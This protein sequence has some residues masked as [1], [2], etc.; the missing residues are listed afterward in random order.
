MTTPQTLSQRQL[1]CQGDRILLRAVNIETQEACGS[2]SEFCILSYINEGGSAVCYEA[3]NTTDGTHGRLK[4]FY[5]LD[6]SNSTPYAILRDADNQLYIPEGFTSSYN[7]FKCEKE[8]FKE[9]YCTLSLQKNKKSGEILN[10]Y[11]PTFEIYEG[12]SKKTGKS[13]GLYIWTRHDKKIITFSD[14]C[15][16]VKCDIQQ[17][18]NP[19]LHLFNILTSLITL[20]RCISALHICDLLHLDIK[21]QNF[22]LAVDENSIIDASNISLFDINTLSLSY[23]ENLRAAYSEGFSA[24]E[25]R[26]SKPSFRSDIYSLG[27]VLFNS[28]VFFDGFDGKYRDEMYNDL[29]R[30]VNSSLLLKCSDCN[31]NAALHDLLVSILQKCLARKQDARY[32]ACS[33]LIPDLISARAFLLPEKASTE[34]DR[35]GLK[36]SYTDLE[37]YFDKNTR[38]GAAGALQ[39]LMFE[40][41][42]YNYTNQNGEVEI[43]VL[44]AGTYAQK[45]LDIA[46]EVSQINGCFAKISAFS[47]N[48]EADKKRYLSCR[49]EFTKF[50]DVDTCTCTYGKSLGS[51]CFLNT[52][53]KGFSRTNK[54][55][56][57][58][59]I[60]E[61]LQSK[62]YTYVFIALGS[63]ELNY[64]LFKE[65]CEL[66]K[67]LG[68]SFVHSQSSLEPKNQNAVY[69]NEVIS[70]SPYYSQLSRMALNCHLSWYDS[71]YVDLSKIK[72]EFNIPYNFN[73]SLSNVLSIKYKLHSIGI[74]DLSDSGK[75]A[76]LFTK[77]CQNNSEI[78]KSLLIS[79]HNRW[80]VNNI[81]QGYR[82]STDFSTL[83]NDIKDKKNKL[84]PC[85]VPAN[86]ACVL[87]EDFWTHNSCE[88]W[89]TA[90]Q[91]ELLCLDELDRASVLLHRHFKETAAQVRQNYSLHA[92]TEKISSL[93]QSFP[94][95]QKA[96]FSFVDCLKEIL[97]G[98]TKQT[99][100]Y[101]HRLKSVQ[102]AFCELPESLLSQSNQT[103]QSIQ[104]SF[105]PILQSC[106]YIDFK[107][108]DRDLIRA[109]PFILTYSCEISLCVPLDLTGTRQSCFSNIH[110]SLLVNP[111]RIFFV[112][113]TSEIHTNPQKLTDALSYAASTADSR[114]MQSQIEVILLHNQGFPYDLSAVK[115]TV[116]SLSQRIVSCRI[117]EYTSHEDLSESL[118]ELLTKSAKL[119]AAEKNQSKTS[120]LL[121]NTDFYSKLSSYFSDSKTSLITPDDSCL[122][123]KYVPHSGSLR[124]RDILNGAES[125][126]AETFS[127]YSE[128]YSIC[129]QSGVRK[130]L[131]DILSQHC[132][133]SSVAAHFT[134]SNKKRESQIF[135]LP[136]F[137]R[138]TLTKL[139]SALKEP[140]L[141]IISK[142]SRIEY[143]SEQTLSV[144]IVASSD[145]L[146]SLQKLFSKPYTLYDSS[147]ISLVPTDTGTQILFDD[148]IVS[149]LDKSPLICKYQ[150]KTYEQIIKLIETLHNNKFL[151]SLDIGNTYISFTFASYEIKELLTNY[152]RMQILDIT[153]LLGADGTFDDIA[154]C[155]TSPDFPFDVIATK[156]YSC[157]LIKFCS[158]AEPGDDMLD[159][160]YD[161]ALL[162]GINQ[163]VVLIADSA[164][165]QQK[166]Y[167]AEKGIEIIV[168][169]TPEKSIEHMQD[170]IKEQKGR[171]T[172]NKRKVFISHSSKDFEFANRMCNI[173][174]QNGLPC[175]IAPRDIPY[176]TVWSEQ[177]TL[178]IENSELMIFIFSENS[179]NTV[180]T[181]REINLAEQQNIPIVAVKLTEENYNPSLKYYMSIYQWINLKQGTDDSDISSFA[182]DIKA[183]LEG[184]CN[185]LAPE[186]GYTEDIEISDVNIDAELKAKFDELFGNKK[187]D[188]NDFVN[189]EK[190][191]ITPF[192]K[193]LLE[194]IVSRFNSELFTPAHTFDETD[195]ETDTS[196]E[197]DTANDQEPNETDKENEN[198]GLYFCISEKEGT[199]LAFIVR[200]KISPL[201]YSAS[202]YTEQLDKAVE[203]QDGKNLVTYFVE[204]VS[205]E[206]N[207]LVTITIVENAPMVIINMGFIDGD[208]VRLSKK[209]EYMQ[210]SDALCDQEPKLVR[211][212]IDEN[213]S[214]VIID[215]QTAQ[216][217]ERK[218]V[219]DRKKRKTIHYMDIVLGKKYFAFELRNKSAYP[220][221]EDGKPHT[222]SARHIANAY[223]YGNEGLPKNIVAAAE[224]YEKDG[225]AESLL[226]LSE[227]FS[228]DPLL[229]NP[230][231]AEYYKQLYL[232]AK[233]KEENKK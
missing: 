152:R 171:T 46:F 6:V 208:V 161:S 227:I 141:D 33:A 158:Q 78:E 9:A 93:I 53:D 121:Q 72:G 200:R 8:Y 230:D 4:E 188:N 233:E 28:I 64:Q 164:S 139:I 146:L 201:D 175:W 124:A 21:P 106:R 77:L 76:L 151:L 87:Q 52:P 35:L 178:A 101:T 13:A 134:H 23:N 16:R 45:F 99:R 27:C 138:N 44:G 39:R 48:V 43:L 172:M 210:I 100:L 225:S 223:Y 37:E 12:V 125:F 89:D 229:S 128:L 15:L 59:I 26:N 70:D 231:D 34:L 127:G 214:N 160:L 47:N 68:I 144:T 217:V 119:I 165:K 38:G 14:Y 118:A 143:S 60:Q 86:D 194:R 198:K 174:E 29:D 180:Q 40:K 5:P 71:L 90:T 192:K 54:S 183:F 66:D 7:A 197:N 176:G 222:A 80:L 81:C 79:E 123:L 50:F 156:G 137:C 96:F 142:D 114:K 190:Q 212:P 166:E 216:I 170:L 3:K 30:L 232:K 129:K 133:T 84:H 98:N 105:Y 102:S 42:L 51:L 126:F 63:D 112:A 149:N 116:R 228:K 163:K 207:P 205:P 179:N 95:C 211:H 113:D 74:D 168:S 213:S 140:S 177:I 65:C 94:S 182:D 181:V 202:F 206:G 97:S 135:Y 49:P 75:A 150:G 73:S 148:L 32:S 18:K 189:I 221:N 58:R 147:K 162:Y 154:L 1:L 193:R 88:K 10:N 220:E 115:E 82:A 67:N 55:H 219:Y 111:Y 167:A 209:P 69:V 107:K 117:V 41:P 204:N 24:P 186:L 203:Y 136:A 83:T 36:I 131:C 91:D 145:V 195:E 199:T 57:R 17:S 132:K 159:F 196:A 173:F 22:G 2:L 109:I 20:T 224:W 11:I 61:I 85:L 25:A 19:E 157:Q 103:L 110:T 120:T 92:D 169:N 218:H 187:Q 155:D 56:N 31:S 215:T 130:A 108:N 191:E 153:S 185:E 184:K 62:K 226:R 104:S 122:Y